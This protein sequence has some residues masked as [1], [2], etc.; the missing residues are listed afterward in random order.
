MA[1][2]QSY[3]QHSQSIHVSMYWLV[4]Y[5]ATASGRPSADGSNCLSAGMPF[6]L[7]YLTDLAY[8]QLFDWDGCSDRG[9]VRLLRCYVDR[10]HDVQLH[11]GNL[12]LTLIDSKQTHKFHDFGEEIGTK[13]II[14]IEEYNDPNELSW[15]ST[16]H[17]ALSLRNKRTRVQTEFTLRHGQHFN[18]MPV[19]THSWHTSLIWIPVVSTII[20]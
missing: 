20:C 4:T 14:P 2:S 9:P 16:L 10:I 5:G 13:M 1:C 12:H 19:Q 17:S 7:T 11:P 18:L 8:V 6:I 15:H 3:Q